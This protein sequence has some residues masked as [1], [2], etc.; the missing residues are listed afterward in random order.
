MASTSQ[1]L[2]GVAR[3]AADCDEMSRVPASGGSQGEEVSFLLMGTPACVTSEGQT[4]SSLSP[5]LTHST[6]TLGVQFSLK[7]AGEYEKLL[8]LLSS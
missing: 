5:A 7:A 3:D 8:L 6:V 2:A 4:A 1:G